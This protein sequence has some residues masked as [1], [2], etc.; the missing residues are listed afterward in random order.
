MNERPINVLLLEDSPTQAKTLMSWLAK[1]RGRGFTVEWV[2]Q[3]AK[4]FA[5]LDAKDIDVILADLS[6]PDSRG[7]DTCL[8]LMVHAP[9]VPVVVLTGT[10]EDEALAIQAVQ[11]GA[12]D[13]LFKEEADEKTLARVLRYAIE[14]KRVEQALKVSK[15]ELEEKVH[16]LETLNKIMLDRE[17]RILELK[18]RVKV[19]EAQVATRGATA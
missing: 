4:A 10:F 1:V 17:E 6:V 13:Y 15:L 7:L 18:E 11:Q 14:R 16:E 9:A 5:R 19:L 3:I 8:R 2:D 12:Q